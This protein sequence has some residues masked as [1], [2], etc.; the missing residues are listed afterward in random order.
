MKDLIIMGA[1]T[2][3][4]VKLVH[5]INKSSPTWNLLGFVDDDEKKWGTDFFGY[6]VLGGLDLLA[7]D[8]YK[9]VYALCFIYGSNM[10]VRMKVLDRM[11]AM[12]LKFANLIHPTVNLEFVEIGNNCIIQCGSR[13]QSNIK[14]GDHCEIGLDCIVGHDVVLEDR[15]WVGPRVTLLGRVTVKRGATL[16]AGCIIKGRATIGENSLVGMGSVVMSDVPDNVTVWGNPANVINR[17]NIRPRH[18]Y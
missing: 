11:S 18:P 13:L 4:I 3:V 12:N 5:D 2:S 6:P 17:N 10:S 14:I 15:V 8:K 1:G 9:H 7:S 16:G